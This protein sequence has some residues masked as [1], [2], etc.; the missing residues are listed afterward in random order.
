MTQL[1]LLV[2]DEL[3]FDCRACEVA[4][5]HENDVPIGLRWITVITV[6][7]KKVGDN[8]IT[9]FVPTTCLHCAKPPCLEA[10]PMR[11]IKKRGDGIVVIDEELCTGCGDCITACPLSVIGIN[12]Q[13][14]VA[15]KCTLCWHRVEKGLAPACVVACQTG[16]IYFGDINK[17][18]LQLRKERAQRR[19]ERV[20]VLPA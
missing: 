7:P 18:S 4:C 11:A 19:I 20:F 12:P 9:K 2:D 15:E 16:A 17:I 8:L 1:A 14:V 3:C 6:G 10:C 13:K 5:K